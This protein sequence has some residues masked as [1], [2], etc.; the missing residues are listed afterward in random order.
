MCLDVC[1][2]HYDL[3]GLSCKPRKLKIYG[4]LSFIHRLMTYLDELER[5][6][7]SYVF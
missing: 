5:I 4:S 6:F 3:M 7:F 2:L 1:K